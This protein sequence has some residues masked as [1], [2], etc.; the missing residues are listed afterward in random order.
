MN[1]R[2]TVF[3]QLMEHVPHKEFQKS[4]ARYRGDRYAKSFS[5]WDQYLAMDFAQLTN[6]ESLRDI[7]ICR[8]DE[9]KVGLVIAQSDRGNTYERAPRERITIQISAADSVISR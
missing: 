9:T 2:R 1:S 8:P 4:A 3:A 6:R 7:E 5:S